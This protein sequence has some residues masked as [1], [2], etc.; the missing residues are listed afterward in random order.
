MPLPTTTSL[1]LKLTTMVKKF[2]LLD[3]GLISFECESAWHLFLENQTLYNKIM[4]VTIFYTLK[5]LFIA[6]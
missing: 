6:L 5:F 4:F 3:D 2:L 1:L